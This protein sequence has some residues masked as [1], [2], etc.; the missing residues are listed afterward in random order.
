MVASLRTVDMT[1]SLRIRK[2]VR[3]ENRGVPESKMRFKGAVTYLYWLFLHGNV[4][5][6]MPDTVNFI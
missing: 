2:R 3:A 4:N 5:P 1:G 6:I